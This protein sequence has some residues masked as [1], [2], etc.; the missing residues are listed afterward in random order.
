MFRIVSCLTNE[1]D[2]RLVLLAAGVC[3]L[4]SFAAIHL[5]HRALATVGRARLMWLITTAAAT[6]YGIWATHF[7]AMLAYTPGLPTGYD[8]LLTILSLFAAAIVTGCGFVIAVAAQDRWAAPAGGA[9]VGVG[10]AVMHYTGMSALE[11]PGH[12]SWSPA[13]VAASI[14]LGML[15]A[16]AAIYVAARSRALPQALLAAA[17]LTLAIVSHH[18]T[19]MGAAEVVPDPTVA[20]AALSLSPYAL[21]VAIAS[22]AVAV[23]GISLVAAAAGSSRQHLIESS[24]AERAEQAERLQAA[25]TNMSQGLCMFD[26][27]QRVVVTNARYLEMYG[28]SAEQA[29]PGTPFRELLQRRVEQGSYPEGPAPDAYVQGL[30]ASLQQGKASSRVTDLP[31][32][33]VIAVSNRAMPG[34]AGW[35]ATHEDITERRLAEARIMHLAHHDVLTDLPNRALFRER[36]EQA[37]AAMHQGGRRLAVLVLDLDRFKEVNDALGHP[38]GDLLLKQATARLRESVREGDTVARLGGD[39]FA[40][41]QRTANPAEESVVLAKRIQAAIEEPFDLDGHNVVVGTSIGIAMAPAD[42]NSPDELLKNADLAVY[43]AKSE[44]R[45]TYRFFEPEMDRRM[46][47]RRGLEKDLRSALLNGEFVLHYQPLVNVERDE[48][49]GFEA[50]L[51]WRHPVRGNVAPG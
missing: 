43:R 47:A 9:I 28:L 12:L 27:E 30:L 5:F 3:F 49:C 31:D 18:F 21:S 15:F 1:H 7:I 10:V 2:W 26:R 14:V 29:K 11:V 50:L 34:G 46:Q 42:G 4:T 48:I 38:V 23:L 40:I 6:G 20:F 17:L 51:R 22:A 39:E 44:A 24:E 25:L 37:I 19:A 45:G 41:V 33:R 8:L 36:L 32:G 35:V 16:A 13:L